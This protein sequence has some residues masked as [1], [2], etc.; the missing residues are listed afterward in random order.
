MPTLRKR[1]DSWQAQIRRDGAKP[2]SRSFRLKADALA[3]ARQTEAE[4]ERAGF[5]TDRR[6]LRA[7]TVGDLLCRYLDTITPHKRSAPIETFRIGVILREK[8]AEVSLASLRPSHIAEHRDNRLR[9]VKPETVRKDLALLRHLFEIARREWGLPLADNPAAEVRKPQPPQARARRLDPGEQ[10]KL[11]RA[12]ATCRNPCLRALM[13][14]ALE[15]GMRRG[16]LLA[17]RWEH[18]DME[19]RTL[20]LPLTKN[21][22]A[23]EVPLSPIAVALLDQ[24]R[25]SGAEGGRILDTTASAVRQAWVRLTRRAKIANLHFHDLRHE[26]IS[27]LF[28]KG[29][30]IPEV[31]VVSGHRDFRMLQRYTHLR[32]E[33]IAAKLAGPTQPPPLRLVVSN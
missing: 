18:L 11:Q 8:L 22:H 9:R 19:R 6:Q 4:I 24:L 28:E 12:L 25:A 10:E 14:L 27:R 26:A 33:D 13:T 7:L 20:L 17:A 32:A 31:A 30:S 15:T 1:G 3:W 21:G 5:S 16:E 2:I 23:R 29:L